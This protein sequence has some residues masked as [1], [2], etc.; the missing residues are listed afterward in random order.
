MNFLKE[1]TEMHSGMGPRID[2][3]TGEDLNAHAREHDRETGE[4]LFK[5]KLTRSEIMMII[6]ILKKNGGHQNKIR[7][8]GILMKAND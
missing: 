1:L 5:D 3:E 7:K 8:L 4:Y 2:R 6:Q